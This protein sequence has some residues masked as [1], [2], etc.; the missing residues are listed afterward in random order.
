MKQPYSNNRPL[1]LARAYTLI[2][3][4]A[5]SAIIA[6]SVGAAASI[7]ASVGQQEEYARRVAV[8]RN[9][10]EN[11]ARLWQLGLRND[12][13]DE[14]MP[15]MSP[16]PALNVAL[17]SQPQIIELGSSTLGSGPNPITVETALC[18]ATVNIGP[19]HIARQAGSTFEMMLCRPT[20]K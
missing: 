15:E 5:A 4:L 11:M 20:I 18:R 19:T 6:V 1:S 7:S 10:Q 17:F 8:A 13:I 16:N 12:V 9:Y 14:I 2:E 3:V